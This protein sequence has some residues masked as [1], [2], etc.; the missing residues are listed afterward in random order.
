M[1]GAPLNISTCSVIH[2]HYF[3]VAITI[4]NIADYSGLQFLTMDIAYCT[5]VCMMGMVVLPLLETAVQGAVILMGVG[6]I[7]SILL[8]NSRAGRMSALYQVLDC[9][10]ILLQA[11]ALVV[12]P[13]IEIS[14]NSEYVGSTTLGWSIPT[15]LFLISL[16]WWQ[17]YATE[18]GKLPFNNFLWNRKDKG[19]DCKD[20]LQLIC[21]L[22]K[23]AIVFG[24]T[25]G[26]TCL[27]QSLHGDVD[28]GSLFTFDY[29]ECGSHISPL[30]IPAMD[31]DWVW[32]WMVS[33]GSGVTAYF[34]A[35]TSAKILIQPI[36]YVKYVELI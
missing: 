28:V 33:A 12:W 24:L 14:K 34:C 10:S 36:R 5:G 11:S 27:L 1:L 19:K 31:L 6:L 7:P 35:R 9:F 20:K 29:S 32:V 30:D 22:F 25:I 3:T 16:G 23:C 8:L 17:N 26:F 21:S 2:V 4:F 13:I 15:S 18:K